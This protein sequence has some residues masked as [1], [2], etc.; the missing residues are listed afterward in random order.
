MKRYRVELEV[1][2]E[3][4]IEVEAENESEAKETALEIMGYDWDVIYVEE[5]EENE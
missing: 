1:I 3:D 2:D 5:L 4:T